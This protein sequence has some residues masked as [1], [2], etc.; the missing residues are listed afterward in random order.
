[1]NHCECGCKRK[2]LPDSEIS[3]YKEALIIEEYKSCRGLI[4][5][6]IEIMEKFEI[7]SVFAIAISLAF[8]ISISHKKYKFYDIST[9]IP[10]FISVFGFIKY[11]SLDKAIG[12]YNKYLINTEQQVVTIDLSSFFKNQN[13]KNFI[14]LRFVHCVFWI[15]LIVGTTFCSI[16]LWK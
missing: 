11:I 9:I 16:L 1:M 13:N 12:I 4:I 3:G 7:Y 15:L 6:N 2:K 14:N 5:K 10:I 8:S